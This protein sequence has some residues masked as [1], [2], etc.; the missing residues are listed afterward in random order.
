MKSVN[1]RAQRVRGPC[2]SAVKV[3]VAAVMVA[4]TALAAAQTS[5]VVPRSVR[6]QPV[7]C[8]IEPERIASLGAPM[9]GIVASINVDR[10]DMVRAGQPLVVM[11]NVV[12]QANVSL[13]ETRAKLEAD[14][15]AAQVNVD[16]VTQRATRA[17]S[18]LAQG[19]VSAQAADQANAEQEVAV[20]KLAQT[21]V[22]RQIWQSELRVA[23]AQLSQRTVYSP[24]DGVV[25]DRHVN[26]GERVEDKP[27]LRLAQMNPLRIELVVPAI[28]YGRVKVGEK[29]AVQPDIPG[30]TPQEAKITHIDRVIDVASN[31]FRVR[32]SLPNP[33]QALPAGARCKVQL[34]STASSSSDAN[35]AIAKPKDVP[36]RAPVVLSSTTKA[37]GQ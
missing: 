24:F 1:N 36:S 14:I 15:L 8:L 12:E 21:Q 29:L 4:M 6:Q 5:D 17:K 25:L 10:G 3:S 2:S 7:G 18:L 9:V 31:T 32:L 16:L 33:G 13:A 22:Q 37:P 35:Q 34:P 27:L 26:Q 28:Y 23:K 19:F 30:V 11:H 20:Q